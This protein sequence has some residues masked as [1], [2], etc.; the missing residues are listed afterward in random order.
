M[1]VDM[2]LF[3]AVAEGGVHTC[4]TKGSAEVRDLYEDII[5]IPGE[6]GCFCCG[7]DS[8]EG[9]GCRLKINSQFG[10]RNFGLPRLIPNFAFRISHS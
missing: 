7:V 1:A 4:N 3:E 6:D 10:I 8:L 2:K 9:E 5:D